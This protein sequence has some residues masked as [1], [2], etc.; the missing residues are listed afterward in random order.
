M[1]SVNG[2]TTCASPEYTTKP[3]KPSVR[4]FNKSISFN[5]ARIKRDGLTSSTFMDGD[6]SQTTTSADEL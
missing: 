5:R 2:V 1:S 4:C 3:V 6:R